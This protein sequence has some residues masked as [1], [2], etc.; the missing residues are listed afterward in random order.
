MSAAIQEPKSSEAKVDKTYQNLKILLVEDNPDDADLTKRL[1][2]RICLDRDIFLAADAEEALD[3]L[4]SLSKEESDLPDLILLDIK[5]PRLSGMEL[6]ERLKAN[7]KFR[8]IPVVMLTGS[9]VSKHVQKSYDLGAVTY[10]I[11]PISEDE[12]VMTLSC[13]I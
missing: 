10:L 11:K 8:C 12:L 7:P 3:C 2:R 5:L 9:L 4:E 1:L 13:L 6:L